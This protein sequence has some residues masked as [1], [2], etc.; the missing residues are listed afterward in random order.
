MPQA[1]RCKE[2]GL[3]WSIDTQVEER[4]RAFEKLSKRRPEAARLLIQRAMTV[5][6]LI[7]LRAKLQSLQT[8][9]GGFP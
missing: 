1:K 7:E 5:D 4:K 3:P 2:R 9:L 8:S 6:P